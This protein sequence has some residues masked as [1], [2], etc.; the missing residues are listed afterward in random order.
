MK[1]LELLKQGRDYYLR[2]SVDNSMTE[3]YEEAIKEL[4]DLISENQT[5]KSVNQDLLNTVIEA[6]KVI[7]N[8]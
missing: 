5:L 6:K 8:V 1:A 2:I 7:K 3:E 4:E